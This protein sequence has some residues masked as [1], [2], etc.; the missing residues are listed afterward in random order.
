M[1]TIPTKL[2]RNI[3]CLITGVVGVA[4][5]VVA[6]LQVAGVSGSPAESFL[7]Y[8]IGAAF[9]VTGISFVVVGIMKKPVDGTAGIQ[10]IM[11]ST[12][13][14]GAGIYFC[15]PGKDSAS[16]ALNGIVTFVIPLFV[17]TFGTILL[18]RALCAAVAKKG[19]KSVASYLV[20]GAIAVALGTIFA[21]FNYKENEVTMGLSWAVLGIVMITIGVVAGVR[22]YK[23]HAAKAAIPAEAKEEKKAEKKAHKD[24]K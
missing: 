8:L 1:K 9:L 24:E 19:A 20:A 23:E 2:I 3:A 10:N 12:L 11:L 18:V 21:V 22:M 13:C 4:T 17:A 5:T 16:W 14:L 15:I 6:I 7:Q